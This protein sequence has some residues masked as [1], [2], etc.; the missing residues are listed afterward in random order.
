MMHYQYT[1]EPKRF[2][3]DIHICKIVGVVEKFYKNRPFKELS[4]P[5][6]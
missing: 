5:S 1:N 3:D 2:H 4:Q 6:R